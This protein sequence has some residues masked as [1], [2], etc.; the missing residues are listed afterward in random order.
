VLEKNISA[1]IAVAASQI[2]DQRDY[3]VA[4]LSGELEKTI[5]PRDRLPAAAD[6]RQVHSLPFSITGELYSELL[7]LSNASDPGIHM[8]LATAMT[9]LLNKYTGRTDIITGMP[10]YKQET[11]GELLNHVV[12]LRCHVDRSSSFKELLLQLRE[13][14]IEAD[15]NK[16]YPIDRLVE[17]LDIQSDG[18]GFPLFDVA[19]LLENIHYKN[20]IRRMPLNMIFSFL[21]NESHVESVVEYNA[22][23]YENNTIERIVCHY[24]QL[25]QNLLLDLDRPIALVEMLT[26]EEKMQLLVDFN[27][28][29]EDYAADQ[30]IHRL[31]ENQV[32]K[33][34]DRPA[35]TAVEQPGVG[36][37]ETVNYEELNRR[38]NRLARTLQKMGVGAESV[39]G[40]MIQR[41]VDMAVGLL[42]ILK[43]GGA[44]LP[45]DPDLP[46]E[47]VVY[48]LEN[49]GANVLISTA[50]TLKGIPFTALQGFESHKDIRISVTPQRK[51]IKEFDQLP[52]PDRRYIKPQNYK[53]KIG[54]ASVTNCI[55]MQT[56][57][58]CPYECLYCHKIWSKTHVHRSAEN[59]FSEIQYFYKQGVTNFAFI[60]DSF[61]LN[62]EKSS[63]LFQLIIK[64]K[65]NV[66]IFFPNG[67]R[68]DIM[69]PDYIDLMV[70]AGTR[71]INLSLETA[72]PRLQKL[73]K[74]NLDLDAFKSVID[75][76]AGKHPGVILEIATMHG[77]PG[78]SEEEAMMTLDFIKSVRWLHFPYIHILKIFPNTEMEAFALE[79][80]VS[81]EDIM[82]SKDRAFH[83][84]PETLPF[85]KSFTR[86]Y[87]ANFLN[88]YF[89]SRERLKHV[90][91]HQM[92]ILSHEALCQK[93]N[94]YL[95][96]DI[97]NLEDIITF[98]QLESE[99]EIPPGY[100]EKRVP[101]R[102]FFDEEPEKSSVP[103][104]ARKILFLDLSQHFSSHS[105]LYNVVEQPLGALYLLTYLKERFGDKI[106]GRIHKAG[107]DFDSFAEL[108]QLIEDYNPD[109]IGIRTLTFFKEFFHETV[110]LIRQ[111]GVTVPIITGGPYA[112]SDY[113]TILK[114][115]NI[116]LVVFGEGEY[117]LAELLEEMLNNDFKWPEDDILEKIHGIAYT[118]KDRSTGAEK[119]REMVLLD[120][121]AG[122]IA[123]E[124]PDN[125][126]PVSRADNMAYVMYTSGSTGRPKGVIVE[127]RQVNNCIFWMQRKFHLTGTDVVA[128]R[129][130]LSFDPS[131]WEIFWPLYIGASARIIPEPYSKD[132][133]F[134]IRLMAE[135]PEL[136]IMYCPATLLNA[137]TYLLSAKT[138]PS[139]LKLPWLV[140]GA[141]PVT[142]EVVK[143][144]YTY[145]K[146]KIVNTYGPT[147]GTINNTY[148]DLDADDPRPIVP[149]G[150]PVANNRI[151]ILSAELEPVP[152]K[153]AGEI[154]IAG[155]SV[156]R[157]Y[158]NNKMQ[159]GERFI[160]NP[161][162]PGL[163][164]RTGDI[165]KWHED[166]NIEIIGRSDQQ[167]KIR[168][169]R[170]ELGEIET[171]LLSHGAIDE[172][173]VVVK[174][175]KEMQGKIKECKKCGIWS[176]Y[177]GTS[178]NNDGICNFCENL[179]QYK[180]LIDQYF[181]PMDELERKIRQGNENRFGKYDCL[182]V[183]ACER[184]ATYALYKLV[185]MGFNVLT[186]TYDSGH[187]EQE[188]LDR[189]SALTKKIGVDH[190]FLRHQRS[191][192][193]MKESLRA[194]DTMCKGCIH[195]SSAL[196]GQYA[197][198]N[199]I[200]YVIGETLSR[201][202]IVENKLYKFMEMG[203]TAVD[204]VE[205]EIEKLQKNTALIDKKIFDLIGI[206]EISDGSLYDTVEYIDFYR[207]CDVTNEE[208]IKF[209]DKK[210]PYW[211]GLDTKSTYS[212]DCKI[213]Q[214]GNFNHLKQKGY[215]YTGAAKSWDKRMKLTTMEDLK[216]D[217]QIDLTA[218][219]HAEFLQNLGY[220]EK[221][222]VDENTKH[223]CAYYIS[224]QDLSVSHL[225]EYLSA[226]IPGYMIP[227]F[228]ISLDQLPLTVNGKIDRKSLPNPDGFRPKLNATYIA[229]ETD[230]EKLIAGIW[231]EVLK[232]DMAGTKDN[233]F[234]LGGSSLDIIHV[235]NKINEKINR[236]IP[237]V[238]MFTYPT[239]SSLAHH[240]ENENKGQT[241]A[242]G[243][244]D[245]AEAIK[246]GRSRAKQ[247]IQRRR[248]GS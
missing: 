224:P 74:K 22:S 105:M 182:L 205:R 14:I 76:I 17:S 43:A 11:A 95:P 180:K 20:Y 245:R 219:D 222:S 116:D 38:A 243:K 36:D 193:I 56:T 48:M 232:V 75:Y 246:E 98:V 229:P 90:L 212:T 242:A 152:L 83:E 81:K 159:T 185:E 213:C 28:N 123:V 64:N 72:S 141:E 166:G 199:G 104:G 138:Q 149:I 87:Q 96:V 233:F 239:I 102:T 129:T 230:L 114:D 35:I 231:Q 80:G 235:G 132:A 156:A 189:I 223:L 99:V 61:N 107:N 121:L 153:V 168:G 165:G 206:K 142:M 88:E 50:Q 6:E 16:H 133:E 3:W 120:R 203:I 19:I 190:V 145:F 91:P 18:K 5:F 86:K 187:Y 157:G 118:G 162:G 125:L 10:I 147:E 218:D 176:N 220:R 9:V 137:M 117:T 196:A 214:V 54:M 58:G 34:P 4:K 68:G 97:K 150:K 2:S 173:V 131:I 151:Y 216:D 188:S 211:R 130:N 70:E 29:R 215:H 7:K 62:K 134:L 57:R 84:L 135:D 160:V 155:D 241:P 175:N 113:D 78:E 174:E 225:R 111:W 108:K 109:L 172:S 181:K 200:K 177:P 53:N 210:D 94:A 25:M 161:F 248:G 143:K 124:N 204:E 158:I 244:T 67:L 32:E 1:D 201:G 26:K 21:R 227:S 128:Q 93:Y 106:D 234:E 12:A 63:Q 144:F 171:A 103:V 59:I 119:T 146:G 15:E 55:S 92:K 202:Q 197:L 154:C 44:Y 209:L 167:V 60:D 195:T 217:L 178:I 140:I 47:R 236:E 207:Y 49:S 66:Q 37:R 208:M 52:I 198:K 139:E 79:H 8:I 240:L 33:T 136:T 85:P 24:V 164:Y 65:L 77:F 89:L 163:L 127:H 238:T 41:S 39:V 247:V 237:I 115:K 226:R 179:D 71:G 191:D 69:T 73:L 101:G 112:S 122:D 194:A 82:I 13:T 184:V 40:I 169:H 27:D 42:A 23:I 110:S 228:F 100:T 221:K 31:F 183:Y 192:E 46:G 186:V 30:T 126:A 45:I 170:I 51:P 148:Y